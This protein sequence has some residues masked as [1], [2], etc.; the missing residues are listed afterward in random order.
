VFKRNHKI[1]LAI[2]EPFENM[3]SLR[4]S[5]LANKEVVET[6]SGQRGH[7]LDCAVTW[8]DLLDLGLIKKDQVP[9]G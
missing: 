9:D 2:P 1:N 8:G 6:L 7:I 5:V 4:N 3:H